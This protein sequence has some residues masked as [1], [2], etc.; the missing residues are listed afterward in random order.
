LE[1]VGFG[2]NKQVITGL[3]REK[4][5]F[6]GIVC[7]DWLLLTGVKF[8]GREVMEAKA[9]GVEDL[10]IPERMEKVI[11]A[12]C[13]QFGGEAIPDELVKLVIKGRITQE[14]IDQ[15][16]RRILGEKF[17]LG[18]FDNPYVDVDAVEDLVGK[19]AFREA[20][21]LAQRKSLVLLKNADS[22]GGSTLPLAGKPKLYVENLAPEAANRFGQV[23][24]KPEEADFAILRLS[25][26]FEPRKGFLERFFHAGS[27]E[28]DTREK[29]RILDICESVPTIVDIYLD[30]PAV[31]PEITRKCAGLIAN[32]G[33]NDSA[34]L[35]LIFGAVKPTGKLPF[36][37]PSSMQA[38][39][40]QKEDLPYDS[41]DPLFPFGFGLEY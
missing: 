18:L 12:G 27:L 7:T 16:A 33:A 14:R 32:F 4:Y 34:V 2:F 13:D 1:A 31:I 11:E 25:A 40:N 24:D 9:W 39:E 37:L 41:Q 10:S 19:P 15:S 8:F 6:D 23:V 30:R 28:F 5:G 22:A 17:R 38:V 36:E 21:E 35:D 20:G 3:L 29:V 26:P